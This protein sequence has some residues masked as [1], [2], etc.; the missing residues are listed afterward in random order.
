[1]SSTQVR[2]VTTRA[3]DNHSRAGSGPFDDDRVALDVG[4]DDRW[5]A[6]EGLRYR[7]SFLALPGLPRLGDQ[8]AEVGRHAG[9]VLLD[10]GEEDVSA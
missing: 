3:H 5:R 9:S 8:L 6:V 1:M 7:Q 4:P 10:I 2:S